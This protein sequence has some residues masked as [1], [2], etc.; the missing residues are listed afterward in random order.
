[1]S[2]GEGIT[3]RPQKSNEGRDRGQV[4]HNK[5]PSSIHNVSDGRATNIDIVLCGESV[6]LMNEAHAMLSTNG[7][8]TTNSGRCR[9]TACIILAWHL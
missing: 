5:P 9:V 7:N 4:L 8:A 3:T 1:M 6:E 2:V